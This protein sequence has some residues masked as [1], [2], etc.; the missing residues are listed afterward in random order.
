MSSSF[1][2]TQSTTFTL[3]HAKHMGAKVAA[4]LKRLQR[5]YVGGPSD[6]AIASYEA[7]LVEFLKA[8]YLETETYGFCR[9]NNFIEPTIQYTAHDLHGGAAND[10]DP[11]KVRPGADISGASFHSY[12]TYSKAW[13]ASSVADRDAFR[14]RLPFIRPGAPEPGI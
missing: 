1:S 9:N 14:K 13:F 8:G 3:T 5:L 11:G 12:M 10:D 7:E 6:L 4:D 2:V